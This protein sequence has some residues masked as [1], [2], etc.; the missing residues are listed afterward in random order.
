MNK[1][2]GNTLLCETNLIK[3]VQVLLQK[4]FILLLHGE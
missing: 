1:N 3:N 4:N 2:Q